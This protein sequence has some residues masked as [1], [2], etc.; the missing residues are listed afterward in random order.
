[1][2]SI[3]GCDAK[4]VAKGLCAKHYM[5]QRRNGDP[6]KVRKVGRPRS[7]RSALVDQM[8]S[9]WSPRT[10][11]RYKA[12]MTLLGVLESQEQLETVQL[13]TRPNGSVNVSRMFDMAVARYVA[14]LEVR[15]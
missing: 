14:H 1:M 3:D 15:G 10:R 9:E 12:A 2:C 7:E 4:T 6:A 11:A 5:R 8:F 13:A